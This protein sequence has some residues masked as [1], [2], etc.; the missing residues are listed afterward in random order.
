MPLFQVSDR[1]ESIFQQM[2]KYRVCL[3]QKQ[4]KR[5]REEKSQLSIDFIA[6]ITIVVIMVN[7]T[8]MPT[9]LDI[10]I[11]HQHIILFIMTIISFQMCHKTE[12]LENKIICSKMA[13]IDKETFGYDIVE[14]QIYHFDEHIMQFYIY[15]MYNI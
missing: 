10:L 6:D 14:L 13:Y 7:T 1:Q 8:Q 15:L 11:I 2:E 5:N 9:T 3:F 4:E 12:F